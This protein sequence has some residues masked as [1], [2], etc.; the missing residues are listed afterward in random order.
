MN[1]IIKHSKGAPALRIFGIGP[2]LIP[3]KGIKK[4]KRLL[5]ENT[6]WAKG[7][8]EENIKKLLANSSSI[9]SIWEKKRMIG[10]GRATSDTVY[11][12]VIWDV[13][14]ASDKRGMGLGTVI[15]KELLKSKALI[16]VRK[17]YLMT[18][19][20]SDFYSEQGFRMI[21]KQKL[22]CLFQD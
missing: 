9:I 20:K 18:T 7:R 16:N 22:F 10:F 11:R 14:V 4:L 21:E 3:M 6:F 2:N 13:V 5:D 17:I 1:R 15:I 19:H 12:A 8:S